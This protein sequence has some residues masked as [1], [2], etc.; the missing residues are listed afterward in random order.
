VVAETCSTSW[1]TSSNAPATSTGSSDNGLGFGEVRNAA[2]N[3]GSSS[4][5]RYKIQ[6]NPGASFS[7]TCSPKVVF[8]GTAAAGPPIVGGNGV[9]SLSYSASAQPLEVTLSGGIGPKNGK[10]YLIGQHVGASLSTGGLTGGTFNWSVSNGDPFGN[11]TADQTIGHFTAAWPTTTNP[12]GF[13]F[14]TPVISS[15]TSQPTP[16]TVTCSAHLNVPAGALPAAGLDVAQNRTC[17]AEPPASATLGAAIGSVSLQGTPPNLI[18]LGGVTDPTWFPGDV[19]IAWEGSVTTPPAFTAS[20]TGNW[21]F[22]QLVTASR[23][24]VKQGAS[25]SFVKNG[26]LCL[27]NW[28]PYDGTFAADGQ[29]TKRVDS[30]SAALSS[31]SQALDSVNARDSFGTWLMYL[32]PGGDSRYV[33]IRKIKWFWYGAASRS[34][35]A[36]YDWKMTSLLTDRG[37][38]FDGAPYPPHPEWSVV[39]LNSELDNYTTP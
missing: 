21:T 29:H 38:S 4:G 5:T 11:Y 36:P 35:T 17:T 19:G 30:P 39:S 27:D 28:Y 23:Y 37:W 15:T 34:T 12:T 14:K 3:G 16:V 33:P 18:G 2:G 9:G 26:Q 25:Q 6:Q 32:P 10:R 1:S 13:Y 8:S 20:G 22:V 7:I 24:R 31:N